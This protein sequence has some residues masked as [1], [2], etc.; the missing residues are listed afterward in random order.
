MVRDLVSSFF[1]IIE[2]KRTFL[3]KS[4]PKKALIGTDLN[5]LLS[6]ITIPWW[7]HYVPIYK[8]IEVFRKPH[9]PVERLLWAENINKTRIFFMDDKN[10]SIENK[11]SE[12][13]TR[14]LKQDIPFEMY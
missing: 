10:R 8:R 3:G 11:L 14:I 7:N 5:L 12:L 4:V 13:G 1:G 6:D 9:I 2:L